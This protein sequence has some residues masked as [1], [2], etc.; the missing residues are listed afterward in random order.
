[1][2]MRIQDLVSSIK[3]EGIDEAEKE[4][5][6]I[7]QAARSQADG[8]VKAAKAEARRLSDETRK[9]LELEKESS[10]EAARQARRDV[11]ISLRKELGGLLEGV[12]ARKIER[13][14]G[15]EEVGALVRAALQGE[16]PAR[17]ELQAKG[18]EAE[19]RGVLADELRKGLAL[20]TLPGIEGFKLVEKDGSGFY[21]LSP[22]ELA[23]VLKPF[24]GNLDF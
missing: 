4:K 24:V 21:D 20:R 3:R 2:E 6:A 19:L 16:D 12:L 15:P 5:A 23:R 18:L 17:Y 1:M 10:I 11:V 22:E 7:I 14:L 8:I 13:S 9:R